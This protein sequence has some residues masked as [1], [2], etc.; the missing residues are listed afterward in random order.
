LILGSPQKRKRDDI[1]TDAELQDDDSDHISNDGDEEDYSAPKLKA[2]SS[3][4]RKRGTKATPSKRV[5]TTKGQATK[6]ASSQRRRSKKTAVNGDVSTIAKP[7]KDT[8]IAQDNILFSK[9]EGYSQLRVLIYQ[10]RRY[11]EY[12][13]RATVDRRRFL[14][15]A[16]GDTKHCTSRAYK[17]HIA[18]MR[19]Q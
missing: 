4:A 19:L 15:I 2:K 3:I 11:H 8:K 18:R 17:L 5:R 7:A 16:D 12:F 1:D 13:C 6:G 10:F 14:G 9:C